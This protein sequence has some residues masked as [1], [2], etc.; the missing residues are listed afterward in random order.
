M[1]F[2][3]RTSSCY[4]EVNCSSEPDPNNNLH[5]NIEGFS[6][7]TGE[8]LA[9]KME[10]IMR[11]FNANR[12]VYERVPLHI[13][14]YDTFEKDNKF[15]WAGHARWSIKLEPTDLGRATAEPASPEPT[16]ERLEWTG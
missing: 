5:L 3:A 2:I 13:T 16:T 1:I 6:T 12:L 4:F 7:A 10:Q 9:Q 15:K 14:E 8:E 11:I